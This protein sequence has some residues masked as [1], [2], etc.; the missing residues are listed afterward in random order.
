M[1]NLKV[2]WTVSRKAAAARS[3]DAAAQSRRLGHVKP[4]RTH[5]AWAR[6]HRTSLMDHQ[7]SVRFHQ[8]NY[9]YFPQ[10]RPLEGAH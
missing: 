2:S 4:A 5:V 1:S 10:E 9:W 7:D 8:G 6:L 3:L